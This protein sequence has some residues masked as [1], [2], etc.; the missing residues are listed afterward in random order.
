MAIPYDK[1]QVGT[2]IYIKL[3]SFNLWGGGE[4]DLSQVQPF[5]HTIEGPP[6]PGTVTG[7]TATQVGGAVAFTWNPLTDPALMAYDILY[8]PTSGSVGT[9]IPLTEAT[10]GSEMT[11][12]SVPPGT[13]TFY[14][15]GHDIADQLGPVTSLNLTV[16][17]VNSV[18]EYLP[19]QPDWLSFEPGALIECVQH[20]TGS[21]VPKS[22]NIA[23]YYTEVGPDSSAPTL[24]SIAGGSLLARTYYVTATYTDSTGET[25]ASPEASL[26]VAAGHLL[27]VAALGYRGNST[28]WNVYV[29]LTTGTETLQNATPLAPLQNWTEPTTG[30]VTGTSAPTLDTTGW[31]V[32]DE[33]VPDPYNFC[34]YFSQIVDT[35]FNDSLRVFANVTTALGPGQSGNPADVSFR[36][37]TWLT[38]GS[39]GGPFV[40][41]TVGYV[42]MRYLWGEIQYEPI[43]A[44]NVSYISAFDVT[45]DTAPVTENNGTSPVSA[46]ATV[47]TTGN[48]TVGGATVSSIASMS[49]IAIGQA[50]T[51]TNIP[52]GTTVL[53]VNVAGSSL[54]MSNN[55]TANVTGESI[56]FNTWVTFPTP[57]HSDPNVVVTPVSAAASTG[58]S[59]SA[60]NITA[61]GFSPLVWNG[62]TNIAGSVNWQSTGT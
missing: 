36:I 50:I 5:V 35:G 31:Q 58:T 28:G 7:F 46:I 49:G 39:S 41:W 3:L 53:T 1:S 26:A 40:P 17:N 16:T 32:F 44:G 59:G 15:R 9:A 56:S 13:W 48:L 30:L 38:G 62:T 23:Y 2:N 20:Y 60:T 19:Q 10:K 14:I 42:E 11:N 45:I 52:N 8:G 25:T 43:T 12:A 51:G 4:Y 29:S 6:L 18:I 55:A 37:N 61:T 21:L 33:F 57:Y 27:E 22:T 24:S 47:S 34:Q 54:T